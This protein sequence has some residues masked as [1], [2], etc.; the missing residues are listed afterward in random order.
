MFLFCL[1]FAMSFCASIYMCLVVTCWERAD[2]LALVC[3][4]CCE[5]VTFPL[6]SW[7][8]CGTWLYRFL[9]FAPLL[10]LQYFA[11]ETPTMLQYTHG[12][13]NVPTLQNSGNLFVH[14]L[15]SS[16]SER[17][18]DIILSNYTSA[19]SFS[20]PSKIPK[21]VFQDQLSLNAGQKYCRMLQ[22]EH[23]AILST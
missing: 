21:I 2:L 13:L 5:F 4:V 7:V 19:S 22:G 16:S 14:R 23:S 20:S 12:S 10:T 15:A 18:R 11:E 1:V 3:G 8:R 9:I 17:N 6:V